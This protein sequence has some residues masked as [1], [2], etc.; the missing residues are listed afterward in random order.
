VIKQLYG[1]KLEL[2]ASYF[3]NV[4][5]TSTAREALERGEPAE[6]IAAGFQPGLAQFSKLR[7]PFLL[8]H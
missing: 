1:G 8:Y 2:H 5:G 3:D 7:E 6:K 4:M